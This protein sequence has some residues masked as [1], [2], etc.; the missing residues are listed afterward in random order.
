MATEATETLVEYSV[1]SVANDLFTRGISLEQ[2][3]FGTDLD[4]TFFYVS[5]EQIATPVK[6]EGFSG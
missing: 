4:G 2:A 5:A 6:A 1:A 3:P